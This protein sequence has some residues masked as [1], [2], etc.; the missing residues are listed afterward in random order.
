MLIE[1]KSEIL[2]NFKCQNSGNCCKAAGYVYI[3][4]ENRQ[5]MAALLDLSLIEFQQSYTQ[6]ENGWEVIASPYFRQNCFLDAQNK[7]AVY[8]ARPQACRTYPDWPNIWETDDTLLTES[9]SC[10]GL[11]LAIKKIT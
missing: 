11:K 6:K 7:C 5:K 9:K 4:P 3:T 2:A 10:P 8:S 1:K